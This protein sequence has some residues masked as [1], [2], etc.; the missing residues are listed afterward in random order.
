MQL[1]EKTGL[2]MN[3][4]INYAIVKQLIMDK[5]LLYWEYDNMTKKDPHYETINKLPENMK[6][7]S[8]Q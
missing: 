2:S 4:Y 7:V 6:E 5:L 1:K 8:K 3:H